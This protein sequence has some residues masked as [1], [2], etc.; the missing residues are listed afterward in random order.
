MA[1]KTEIYTIKSLHL[2]TIEATKFLWV[3]CTWC[4]RR[5]ALSEC[6]L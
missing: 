6:F 5:C 1:K 2:E 3:R 4:W